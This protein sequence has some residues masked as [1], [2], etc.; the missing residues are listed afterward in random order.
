MTGAID[1]YVV[2]LGIT[3]VQHITREAEEA[4][5]RS[6][7]VLFVDE[8]FGVEEFITSL[9]TDAEPLMGLYQEGGQR[10]PTYLAMAARVLDAALTSPPVCFATYGHPQI[11][12]YPTRLIQQGGAALG[13]SVRVLPG[14]SALDTI[15]TGLQVDPGPQ[16]LQM[17]EATDV[18]ARQ[19]PLQ[20][21]VPCLLWQISSLESGLYSR[22]RG[23]ASR[24]TRLR[25]YLLRTYPADHP[26]T[27]T[28]SPTY[29]LLGPWTE[30]FRLS[31]LPEQ[32]ARGLQAGTL[33][34]PPIAARPVAHPQILHDA[35][36]PAHNER[37]TAT[38]PPDV[39]NRVATDEL[40]APQA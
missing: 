23:N 18:L 33:Y 2:G 20:P 9:G 3:A 26:V 10:R 1:I 32:L 17:Y 25:D 13:L 5:R 8:G 38:V 28:L 14:I 6:T 30:T 37:I 11:Y 19:R 27:I 29:Q 15:L 31:E 40:A 35:Y 34:I 16:G 39:P 4:L 24:F 21:D 22:K 7:K 36:D 12:V